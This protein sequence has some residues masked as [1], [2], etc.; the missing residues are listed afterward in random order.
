MMRIYPRRIVGHIG[1]DFNTAKYTLHGESTKV[2][3]GQIGS[4]L[5]PSHKPSIVGKI[6]FQHVIIHKARLAMSKAQTRLSQDL[7]LSS[8]KK[9]KRSEMPLGDLTSGDESLE[10][11]AAKH[12]AENNPDHKVN[13]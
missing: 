1:I 10:E 3:I 4:E 6:I 2:P 7:V 9:R 5:V 11:R 13:K 12:T 8:V